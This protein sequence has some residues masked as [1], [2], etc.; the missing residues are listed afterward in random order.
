M[1]AASDITKPARVASNGRD[2]FVGSSSS[3]TR[4][5]IAQ[6]P[7]RISGWMHDS[8]PPART[9]SASPRRISSAPSPTACE[10]VAQAETGA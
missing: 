6:K 2:A 3:A 7:A 4:P 5:R 9:A 10:P 8:V 1:H